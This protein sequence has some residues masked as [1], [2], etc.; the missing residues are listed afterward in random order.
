MTATAAT[1][2]HGAP[3]IAPQPEERRTTFL[4]TALRKRLKAVRREIPG[5]RA[6]KDSER[7]HDIRVAAR[8][9]RSALTV[10]ADFFPKRQIKRWRK[11]VRRLT[12]AMGAARDADVQ[13]E[14][15]KAFLKQNADRRCRPGIRRLLRRLTRQR[16]ALQPKVL[17]ELDRFEKSGIADTLELALRPKKDHARSRYRRGAAPAKRL[18]TTAFD[19]LTELLEVML[20]YEEQVM[21][22]ECVTELHRMRIAARR[23]RYAIE[24]FAPLYPDRLEDAHSRLTEIQEILGDIHDCDLWME[25]LPAFLAAEQSRARKHDGHADTANSLKLGLDCLSKERQEHRQARFREF[26]KRWHVLQKQKYWEK[27]R[28]NLQLPSCGARRAS[29]PVS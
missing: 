7:M 18:Y 29:E 13:I 28:R 2:R 14:F 27:L 5:I 22:P 15:L 25:F 10:L 3:A 16:G 26:V 9:L 24:V 19:C 20:A 23:L 1:N 11:T 12:R 6:G 4:A 17:R 21:R 8:R